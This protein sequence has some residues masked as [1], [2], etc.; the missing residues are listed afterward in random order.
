MK[1]YIAE[2]NDGGKHA[3]CD[4]MQD[5]LEYIAKEFMTDAES[6]GTWVDEDGSTLV[7]M[8]QDAADEADGNA[9]VIAMITEV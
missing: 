2:L 1:S 7:W 4:S 3:E 9:D 5:A 8:T 6:L